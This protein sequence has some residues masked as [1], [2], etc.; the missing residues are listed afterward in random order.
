MNVQLPFQD[1]VFAVIGILLFSLAAS[2]V[3]VILLNIKLE[4]RVRAQKK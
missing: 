1:R 3:G 4:H 2:L